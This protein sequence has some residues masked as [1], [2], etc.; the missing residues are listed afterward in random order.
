MHRARCL[1]PSAVHLFLVSDGR[2]L[3]LRR[4]NTGYENGNYTAS[5]PVTSTAAKR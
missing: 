5:S 1:F 3:L 2:V 4:H